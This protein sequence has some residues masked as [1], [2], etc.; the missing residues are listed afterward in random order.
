MR[1]AC[2]PHGRS[3]RAE[4]AAPARFSREEMTQ[5]LAGAERDEEAALMRRLRRLRER[6]LLRVMARDLGGL[7]DLEEV[8]GTMS[9]LAELGDRRGARRAGPHRGG[10]GQARRARAQRVLGHRPHLRASRR[11]GGPGALRARRTQADPPAR[12]VDRGRPR[13][14]CGHAAAALR[15][16]RAA[17]VQLRFSRDL[18]HHAGPRVGALR[19]DQ[20][21]RADGHTA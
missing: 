15:R 19:L 4:L 2:L 16:L 3:S 12:H 14:P 21:A 8:C 1:C 7:A 13:V 20:G 6:V 5:A 9:D 10:D 17:R 18:L 11:S